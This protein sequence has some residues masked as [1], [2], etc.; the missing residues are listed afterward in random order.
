MIKN[1][2]KDVTRLIVFR[3]IKKTLFLFY[4]PYNFFLSFVEEDKSIDV[5]FHVFNHFS[6]FQRKI[7]IILDKKKKVK[8]KI[9]HM[10]TIL[11]ITGP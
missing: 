8:N 7:F 9:A 11:S 4:R 10:V 5:H 3:K 2:K 1:M 6:K